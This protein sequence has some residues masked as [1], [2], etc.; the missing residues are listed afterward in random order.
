M[1]T[2]APAVD[3][4]WDGVAAFAKQLPMRVVVSLLGLPEDTA[5]ALRTW[6]DVI[7]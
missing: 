5:P 1:L 2:C 3:G 6:A 4:R 7:E